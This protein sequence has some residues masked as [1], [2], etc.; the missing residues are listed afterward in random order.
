MPV[1][2]LA[3]F[4]AEGSIL[5]QRRQAGKHHG[6][7]WEFP[8]G[9]VEDGEKPRDSLVREIAEELAIPLDP[10]SLRCAFFAEEAGERHVV[11]FL[12]TSFQQGLEP[13]GLDG[14]EWGWFTP[15][16][17]EELA[18]APMDRVLLSQI[19]QSPR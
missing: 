1:V 13:E 19:A 4:D 5:L 11:L 3:L 17:A 2:A 14:Q 16:E 9:K 7:L 12:Y 8:G 6:G 10:D 18:L 15:E